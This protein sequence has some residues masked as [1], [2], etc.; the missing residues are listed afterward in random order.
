MNESHQATLEKMMEMTSAVME[1]QSQLLQQINLLT[2]QVTELSKQVNGQNLGPVTTTQLPNEDPKPVTNPKRTQLIDEILTVSQ[3]VADTKEINQQIRDKIV[4]ATRQPVHPAELS[5]VMNSAQSTVSNEQP[6]QASS[7]DDKISILQQSSSTIR[8]T[9]YRFVEPDIKT[10]MHEAIS[11]KGGV[12]L[13]EIG[14]NARK[15]GT[16]IKSVL[17]D[18]FGNSEYPKGLPIAV[19]ISESMRNC[20]DPSLPPSAISKY[21]FTEMTG[22]RDDPLSGVAAQ[23]VLGKI[24]TSDYYHECRNILG[25][26]QFEHDMGEEYRDMFNK[27]QEQATQAENYQS[28]D[29]APPI[30]YDLN[31]P[32]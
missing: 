11:I 15:Q 30:N 27:H 16:L 23:I 25:D 14:E 29:Q 22:K 4:D 32:A 9:P 17:K 8:N 3:Q 10:S 12:T 7:Y 13:K 31:S 2:L 6:K 21:V 24:K 19:A 5:N 18:V 26:A 20:T 1:Q 28:H